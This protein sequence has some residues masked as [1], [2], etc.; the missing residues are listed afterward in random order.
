MFPCPRRGP[1]GGTTV[2]APFFLSGAAPST[3]LSDQGQE[4]CLPP[5]NSHSFLSAR[6]LL[7]LAKAPHFSPLGHPTSL[8]SSLPLECAPS[9]SFPA[10]TASLLSSPL[11]PDAHPIQHCGE[12]PGRGWCYKKLP[13]REWPL[14]ATSWLGPPGIHGC[15]YGKHGGRVGADSSPLSRPPHQELRTGEVPGLL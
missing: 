9:F 5:G 12:P 11:S 14:H 1:G 6:F 4:V 15:A 3:H 13:L 7:F 8:C 10:L 2:S